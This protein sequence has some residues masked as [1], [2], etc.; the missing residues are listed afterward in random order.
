LCFLAQNSDCFVSMHTFTTR[1]FT[2]LLAWAKRLTST[3]ASSTFSKR[4]ISDAIIIIIIGI[5]GRICLLTV[6]IIICSYFITE[7]ELVD[8][9]E[10]A[11]LQ[12]LIDNL[13][14]KDA[15]YDKRPTKK[16]SS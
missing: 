10:L 13:T 12:E 2:R 4:T 1:T 14:K 16:S 9:R 7:F 5:G 11:P 6:T 8:K 15:K 3:P